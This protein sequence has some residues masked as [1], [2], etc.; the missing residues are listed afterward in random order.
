LT[1]KNL[2]HIISKGESEIL[3]LK[4]SFNKSVIE[5]IVAFSNTR[6]GRIVI[7]VNDTK[8][9]I[10]TTLNKESIQNWINEIKQNTEPSVF[11]NFDILKIDNNTLIV[12]TVAEFP[13]KPV[14]YRNKYY[15][16][17]NNANHKLTTDEIVEMRFISLSYSFDAYNINTKYN[18]L[19][20]NALNIFEKLITKTG[21]F[22]ATGNLKNDLTKLGF[23]KNGSLTRATELL[24]GTHHTNIHI[25]RFKNAHTIIDDLVIRSPL[26]LALDETMDFIKRNI[27]LGYEFKNQIQRIEKWEYPILVLR[28]L[29]LNAIVHRDYTNPTDLIIKIFDDK[30]EFS[31]AGAFLLGVT[32]K[33]VLTDNYQPKHRNKL[34]T[35]AFYLTG[36]IE[37]Y[38]T[39]FIRMRNWLTKYPTI[40]IKID[41][42]NRFTVVSICKKT[43]KKVT[44]KVT[45]KEI[46]SLSK[47]QTKIIKY[48]ELN[49]KITTV[50]LSKKLG[51]SDRKIK[52]NIKKL[53]LQSKLTRNG[54]ARGGYWELLKNE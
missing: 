16:R 14:S 48:I 28:E 47:N 45:K 38:G 54:S 53:K 31:N 17:K 22:N 4:S 46:K 27:R 52:E 29:L 8:K 23:I 42:A 44:K 24:L 41:D 30:I 6:G 36:A 12:I 51:I 13:L 7:G 40:T 10:G 9:I 49:N 33:D 37:K 2:I 11:P 3:E 32:T 39:G 34:L 1:S 19:D 43:D 50:E 21:R 35:E 26:I 25:G 18:E 20:K 5:T 15:S